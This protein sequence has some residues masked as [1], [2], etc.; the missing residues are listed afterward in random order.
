MVYKVIEKQ[1]KDIK[2]FYEKTIKELIEFFGINWVK[3]RPKVFLVPDRKTINSLMETETPG[4]VVGWGGA[5]IGGVFILDSKNF[6]KESDNSYSSE[7]WRALI[8]HELAHCFYNVATGTQRKPVWLS[9]GVS[10]YLSG[11]NQW[12]KSIV[13]F[14]KMLEFYEK[15]GKEAYY[16]GGFAVERLVKKHGKDKLLGLLKKIKDEKPNEENFAK[17]FKDTYGFELSY[18]SLNKILR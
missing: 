13:K 3:N 1:D 12:K 10:T 5:R 17:L 16:E 9:E 11:Q 18:T 7:K 8:K 4:W 14:E 6:E 2:D 15:H